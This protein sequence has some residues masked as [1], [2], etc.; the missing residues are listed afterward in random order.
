MAE[1]EYGVLG[2]HGSGYSD[3]NHNECGVLENEVASKK[4]T[5]RQA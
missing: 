4:T 2:I 5:L 3:C 1:F